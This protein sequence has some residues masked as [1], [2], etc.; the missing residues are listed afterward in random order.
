[1]SG[2]LAD[3]SVAYRATILYLVEQ[4]DPNSTWTLCTGAQGEIGLRPASAMT[5]GALFSMAI[6]ASHENAET[7]VRFNE[8]LLALRVEVD[9]SALQTGATKSS[10][11]AA[12]NEGILA[13]PKLRSCPISVRSRA[14]MTNLKYK[15]AVKP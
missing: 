14:D 4:N 9:Q 11:L 1:V 13:K 3:S 2:D 15:S 10:E 8:V 12:V 7:N 6:A 5:Q